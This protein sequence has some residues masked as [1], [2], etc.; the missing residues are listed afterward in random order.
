LDNEVHEVVDAAL[1]DLT[2]G[3]DLALYQIQPTESV[4]QHAAAA[5]TQAFM[6]FERGY[7]MAVVDVG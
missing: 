4:I 1:G 5:A 2:D 3:Q 7:R 6:A